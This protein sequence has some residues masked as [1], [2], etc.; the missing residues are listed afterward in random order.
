M[1]DRSLITMNST[2]CVLAGCV[3]ALSVLGA[4]P[5]QA[6]VKPHGLF[7]DNAVLQRGMPVPVWGTAAEG[8]KV[9][10][11]FR[12]QRVSTTASGGKWSVRLRPLSAGGPDTLTI[13]GQNTVELKNVLV[14]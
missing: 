10:V 8:E 1:R 5:S 7:T 14:G 6:A 9:T 12:G 3:L 2:R 13:A 11:S 4:R